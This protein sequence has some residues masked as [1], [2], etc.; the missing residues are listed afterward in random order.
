MVPALGRTHQGHCQAGIQARA[1]GFIKQ[2]VESVAKLISV[3]GKNSQAGPEL[4]VRVEPPLHLT[5]KLRIELVIEIGDEQDF[6]IC[7][8]P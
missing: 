2:R 5:T 8:R 4:V 1:G 7:V 3:F 6:D